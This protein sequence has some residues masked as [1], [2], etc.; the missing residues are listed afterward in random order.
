MSSKI[1]FRSRLFEVEEE[2]I[3]HKS[4]REVIHHTVLRDSTV[5]IFPLTQNY[6]L[7]LASEFRAIYNKRVIAAFAGFLEGEGELE[8]AK[9]ELKEEAGITANDWMSLGEFNLAGSVVR[10]KSYLFLARGL[11][12]GEQNLE[13]GEDIRIIKMPL[14]EAVAE[15]LR[16]EINISSTVIGILKLDKMKQKGEI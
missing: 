7:Y 15:V 14:S 2:K 6:E 11:T 16:G 4:G 10:G 8:R 13:D 3:K 1:V 9:K 5:S 12:M